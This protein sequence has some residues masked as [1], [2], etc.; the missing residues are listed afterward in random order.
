VDQ[1]LD[2]REFAADDFLQ[3]EVGRRGGHLEHGQL[4]GVHLILCKPIL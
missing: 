4:D 3:C 1:L 2:R